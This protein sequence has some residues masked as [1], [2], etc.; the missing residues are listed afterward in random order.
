MK[1]ILILFLLS[2][3]F[4]LAEGLVFEDKSENRKKNEYADI[5]YYNIES[6]TFD[7]KNAGN[8]IVIL[9][10]KENFP[11]KFE[12]ESVEFHFSF[13][14]D[15]NTSTGDDYYKL[16]VEVQFE[17]QRFKLKEFY[18]DVERY[19]SFTSE[20]DIEIKKYRFRKNQLLLYLKGDCFNTDEP[21][22]FVCDISINEINTD[23]I[24]VKDLVLNKKE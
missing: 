18:T 8:L 7:K 13:D 22:N 10:V 9:T 24:Y 17:V 5:D 1:K 16:G 11:R 6:V 4:A 12:H 20:T 2:T 3:H 23:K 19:G 15:Q 14:M 21:M